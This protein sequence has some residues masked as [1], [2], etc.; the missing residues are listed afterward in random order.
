MSSMSEE[1]HFDILEEGTEAWNSWRTH[2]PGI[3]PN[4]AGED[5]SDLDLAEANLS[6][7]NLI[8]ADLYQTKLP[9]ANL[10]MA[11]MTDAD[12]SGV[13]MRGAD[14]YKVNMVNAFL[15]EANL[16]GAYIAESDLSGA[17]LRGADLRQANLTDTDLSSS[18]LNNADLSGAN[19]SG[20]NITGAQLRNANFTDANMM[21]LVYG[22]AESRRGNYYGIRGLD[23]CYGNAL[24]VRDAQDQDYLDTME[25]NIL[26]TKDPG[27]RRWKQFWFDA[28]ALIDYGRSLSRPI[29]YA[30]ILST[31][32]GLIYL[33]D[34]LF[35]WGLMNYSNSAQ[36]WLTPFYYS[37]VT[38]TT[39]GFGDITPKHWIGEIIVITEVILGYLTLGLMLSILANK[40]AQRS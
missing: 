10:K 11:S 19:L 8:D 40:V 29:V 21:D 14:L 16:S 24:F 18:I 13:D 33:M 12:C 5:L 28:W 3:S 9:N 37:I 2:D 1:N 38:Y 31:F 6:E 17:D 34:M 7:A 39:L 20:A 32:Y 23:S 30:V 22:S 36:S 25:H 26:A 35:N 4:L 15:V 27:R